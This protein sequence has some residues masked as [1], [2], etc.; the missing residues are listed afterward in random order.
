MS[1]TW[2]LENAA[3]ESQGTSETFDSRSDAESWVGESFAELVEQGVD[4]VRLFDGD[5]EVYGPRAL[6][7][8]S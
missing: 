2:K 3:G 8:E 1:W 6:H 7:P 4:Q 5:T